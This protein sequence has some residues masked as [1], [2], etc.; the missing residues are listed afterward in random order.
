MNFLDSPLGSLSNHPSEMQSMFNHCL[1]VE[2]QTM[3]AEALATSLLALRLVEQCT[4]AT[5][6][7]RG[8]SLLARGKFDLLV[9]DLLFPVGN[10]NDFIAE[11]LATKPTPRIF[12]VT[13]LSDPGVLRSI[14]V[15]P[16]DG[17]F[18]KNEFFGSLREKLEGAMP[19]G[20]RR[21]AAM[22][23]EIERIEKC[24]S[25]REREVLRALGSGATN[26]EIA[27]QLGISVRT[28]ETHRKNISSKV[29]LRAGE[30]IRA[31]VHY[32]DRLAD[33]NGLE[34]GRG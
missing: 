13:S 9:V 30:L 11:A 25:K 1:V 31:A 4:V 15:H 17:V 27:G 16:V 5:S 3:F 20:A 34:P 24:L 33:V 28:V 21:P 26:Q 10:A 14:L 8:L 12:V 22:S 7:D 18:S 2:D 6:L 32:R 23:E 29:D 19:G